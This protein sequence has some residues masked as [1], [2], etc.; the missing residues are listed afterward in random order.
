MRCDGASV[1][2]GC[3]HGKQVLVSCYTGVYSLHGMVGRCVLLSGSNEQRRSPTAH[4][5]LA[6]QTSRSGALEVVETINTRSNDGSGPVLLTVTFSYCHTVLHCW[7]TSSMVVT[8]LSLISDLT[9]VVV[10]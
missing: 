5:P 2:G 8:I 9:T 7:L 3:T 4:N 10:F 1:L 6:R